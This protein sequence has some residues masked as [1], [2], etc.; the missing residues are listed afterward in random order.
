[1]INKLGL[2]ILLTLAAQLPCLPRDIAGDVTRVID[3]D[4]FKLYDGKKEHTIRMLAIDA[5]EKDQAWGTG[6]KDTLERLISGKKV[7][8]SHIKRDIYHRDVGIVYAP[9]SGAHLVKME[10]IN[11]MMVC[12]GMAW[13]YKKYCGTLDFAD[14]E[15]YARDWKLGIWSTESP[16]IAPWE[17][18]KLKRSVGIKSPQS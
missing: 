7:V 4:T 14:E 15:D 5:P 9:I 11:E 6:A 1:M 17:F 13:F 2:A 12:L 8:V 18:R 3:G 16:A 10:N